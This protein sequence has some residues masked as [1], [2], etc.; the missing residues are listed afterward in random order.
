MVRKLAV[1]VL[2][3]LIV[4]LSKPTQAQDN[5]F[6]PTNLEP[7]T[8][9][10][11]HRIEQLAMIGTGTIESISWSPDSQTIAAAGSAGI[12]LFDVHNLDAAPRWYSN[13]T[14]RV[15]DVEF[16]ADGKT[17]ISASDDGTIH[18]W[19]IDS[20]AE[21]SK[22]CPQN[23]ET[24]S[25]FGE[26]YGLALSPDDALLAVGRTG[27]IVVLDTVTHKALWTYLG[28]GGVRM[29]FSPDGTLLA[30]SGWNNATLRLWE[31]DGSTIEKPSEIAMPYPIGDFAFVPGSQMVAISS[32]VG[33]EENRIWL[34]DLATREQIDAYPGSSTFAISPDGRN[35]ATIQLEFGG[36]DSTAKLT[37]WNLESHG[38][39]A[40]VPITFPVGR[41]S[42]SPDGTKLAGGTIDGGLLVWDTENYTLLH[43]TEGQGAAVRDIALIDNSLV[44]L[45]GLGYDVWSFGSG[46]TSEGNTIRLWDLG[47]G[48]QVN[49]WSANAIDADLQSIG[50]LSRI[51]QFS[52]VVLTQHDSS[53]LYLLDV[54]TGK[55]V[56][57]GTGMIG[58]QKVQFSRDDRLMATFSD[59][60]GSDTI[61]V[62][63]IASGITATLSPQT[64]IS[65]PSDQYRH[66]LTSFSFHPNNVELLTGNSDGYVQFWDVET[67]EEVRPIVVGK[68]PVYGI[69]FS[70]DGA[71]LAISD[72]AI[73]LF[74]TENLIEKV[75]LRREEMPGLNQ[76][77]SF[78]EDDSLISAIPNQG[79]VGGYFGD[80]TL[81]DVADHFD[82]IILPARAERVIFSDDGTLMISAGYDGTIRFWGIRETGQ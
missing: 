23:G 69:A 55:L 28:S 3:L 59:S 68:S 20:G 43:V 45:D 19:N 74:D 18:W 73:H 50:T 2:L 9:S 34:F 62:W 64:A 37:V 25:C 46:G 71:T 12:R 66:T 53:L 56:T 1:V 61:L 29:G 47:T 27:G 26:L 54:S 79:F 67:G 57:I 77:P 6:L 52:Q 24:G 15:N 13:H 63:N 5:Q 48:Q 4:G 30:S 39:V 58:L 10:N 38:V 7:I 44:S 72:G 17:L 35:L 82:P 81:W 11:A 40:Q 31:V 16:S 80:I 8:A 14:T 33:W 32:Y 76:M 78:S 41:L 70:L 60:V 75:V 22:L 21:L 65:V 49:V 36:I 42:Y 51:P